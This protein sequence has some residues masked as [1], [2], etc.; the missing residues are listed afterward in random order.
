M[1]DSELIADFH[2]VRQAL[3]GLLAE[4]SSGALW[5]GG[6]DDLA[7]AQVTPILL[8]DTTAVGWAVVQGGDPE[9]TLAAVAF[10]ADSPPETLTT[11]RRVLCAEV[12]GRRIGSLH[13][14]RDAGGRLRA[15][16]YLDAA[17]AGQGAVAGIPFS[18]RAC[19]DDAIYGDQPILADDLA[20][21]PG[22]DA[23]LYRVY[24]TVRDD[25]RVEP[26]LAA[27]RGFT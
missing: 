5:I 13:V 27:F 21:Q 15:W 22:A 10:S 6:T 18:K 25:N 11:A 2:A 23:L 1:A 26:L 17:P 14:R 19:H 3:P 9:K 16:R 4:M 24:R 8:D 12:F 7:D 20:G